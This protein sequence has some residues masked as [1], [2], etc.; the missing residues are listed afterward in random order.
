MK[1]FLKSIVILIATLIV[2][3]FVFAFGIPYSI[4][5]NIYMSVTFKKWSAL[6]KLTWRILDG[7]FCAFGYMIFHFCIGLDML[8]NVFGEIFEDIIT[9]KEDTDFGEKNITVSSSTGHLEMDGNLNK[10]GKIFS[11]LLSK[12]FMQKSHALDSWE[13][14]N[15]ELKL[16]SKY[17]K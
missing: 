14:R 8:W 12:A 13:L 1:E 9:A 6:F 16:K 4:G 7:A 17:F 15:A 11:R 10:A 3:F 2:S 5:Y